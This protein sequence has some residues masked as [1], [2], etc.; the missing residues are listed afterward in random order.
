QR[1]TL[2]ACTTLLRS[3]E[4]INTMVDQ[5]SAFAA[6]VTRVA[7][8]VGTE[9]M[10]GGQANVEGVSGV[11]KDLTDNFNQLALSLTTQ[12]RAIADVSTAVTEGDLTRQVTVEAKGEVD[13]LKQNVNQMIAN[14]RATTARNAD[15][16]WLNSNLARFSGMMQGQRDLQA[17][18]RLI[19]SA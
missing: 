6:E 16:D 2:Y 9:G 7:R 8:E 19:M 15:Q 5:L 3:K 12:V 1:V 10:L 11:W 17:V 13:A 4:T 18:S 14:L